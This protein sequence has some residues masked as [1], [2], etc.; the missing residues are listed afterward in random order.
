MDLSLLKALSEADAIASSEQEVRQILLEEADRLQ[1]EVRFDGLGSVL[2]RLN[3]STGPKVMICAHMDEVGFMVRSISRE[4]AIDVLPVGNVRMAA[5]QLQSVR[6]TTREECKIPGLLDGDRQGN[7]VSAMRVDIGARSCDEVMQAGIRPGDRVTFDTTFQVLPH[8]RVM[9]KAFDDRLGCYL[10]VTLLRELHDA[11]LPAEVW[12][13]A[14]SSEEVG[15]RGG[16]TATRAVS[17][18][19]AI[20]LDTACWAKNFDYGAANH[21]QNAKADAKSSLALIGTGTLFNDSCSLNISGSDE[22]QARRVLEEYIQ[23]RF[24]DSDSVQPTLAELTAHPLPSS[25]SRL[26]P[27]LLY[28]NVLA[29]GVGVGTLTLLQSDSLDSYRV[30]PASAQDS[31]LLEHSLATL[32][33]QLNQQ[34]RERDG[35]SKTIL[36]A[37]LSLIQDDEFAGNIRHLMAE[38]HQGL[39]AAIISN[40]EQICAKLSASASDYL[41]ERVSDIRDISEQLLHITW[42]ELKPRNNL[43]LEKPT[44]L[45]AEDLTPSQFLSLDLK[46]L[47]GMILEKTGRTSHTLILA[48]A[49]AIPVLSGLPLDAIARYAGQPAVLDAQCGVL[50]INPNDAVSGYYQVAQT[51]ADKRQKQQA[52]AAAQLAYS[53]DKKRIDIAAN[54]GT[55]LEAP[56]AFANGAEGVGLFRTEMLYMDRDSAPDEQEQF[57]AYQQVLLAAG[58]KPI[59]FRTMD[60]GGDKSIPYLNIPQEENPFLGYRAVRIYP[61]FAGLFRTQLRAILRA[62]SFGNAQLMIPMVHSLDQILWVKGEIQK[63]I[64][65]LKRDG[66]RHAETIT[67]GIMVEVPSVCY[68][69][70]HFCDEVDFFSIGSNDMTQYLYA[71]DRNNPRVSPLYNPITP[72]FLRM[73]QQIVTAAHQRGKWVGICGELGGESRYLP[74]LLGLGLDELSMS[75]PRIPAVKSQLRQLDSEACRELARQACECRSAQEIEALLTAFAPE[76]DVRP[77][78]ALE[79]IFVDQSFSNK[80]QAIQF[81]CGNLGVNGRTEHPFELEEDVWQR[82]EIVTTGVGF[83]VAIP[84]TKS[85]WIRHSSISIARLVKPVDWQSEMGEVEL[86]IMLTLGANE[87]MNH[88]KVFSQLARKLVNKNFRQSLFAAQDAQS[89]LTLLETELTF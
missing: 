51:L 37:H 82:E 22:E 65:E 16:Q 85:Q 17:P 84:H 11:E 18:D 2:I 42:P 52:Q 35:E 62:A 25:L 88:V 4:G 1:K 83:G 53:R 87:G 79:N 21:R 47:A 14:S 44:I 36:S 40:M 30:I 6:I 89:I 45:V 34:L 39:G 78:L 38:Q 8:Q 24:I 55:A 61:E 33:E 67:L 69:I 19:V 48:R 12:L 29:S 23:V 15:L 32:A 54:I 80:E 77:L 86:V 41:R 59:I 73:L 27:D 81:L 75:S 56:G 10:L 64:V 49:S 3:E 13:V 74:L 71:V 72:S 76:E 63:A 68:I 46:N 5:R 26:N 9:G 20:V 7:D 70:D 58:D 28:G 43:V 31:T 66:L 60:I 57:E 50:A